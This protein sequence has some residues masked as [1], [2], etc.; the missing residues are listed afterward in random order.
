MVDGRSAIAFS[1]V[2]LSPRDFRLE[3]NYSR[4]LKLI[5]FGAG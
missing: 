1:N 3:S 5:Y 2:K 4:T